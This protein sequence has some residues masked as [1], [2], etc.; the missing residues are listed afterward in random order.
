MAQEC[1]FFNAELEG[2]E[3]DRVYNAEQFA[4]Y[5]A[6]FIANGV[7]GNSMGELVVLEN[8]QANM[9]VDV[10]SG[11]AWINGWWY[12]NTEELNLPIALADGVLNRKDIVVLRWGNAERDMWLQVLQGEPSGEPIAPSIV[13]NADYYDLK[14]CEISIPAGTSR[15]TQSLITDTR[16][17]NNVCGLV[18]GVVDQIDTTELYLQFRSQFEDFKDMS[19]EEFNE[20]FDAIKG[21]ITTDLGIRLQLEIGDLSELETEDKTDLVSAINEAASK[22]G[23]PGV[24]YNTDADAEAD[25]ANIPEDSMVYTN[26]GEDEPINARQIKYDDG[27]QQGSDVETQINNINNDLSDKVERMTNVSGYQTV[28]VL[29]YNPTTKKLGLKVNGADTVIPFNSGISNTFSYSLVNNKGG[30][31]DVDI[32][33]PQGVSSITINYTAKSSYVSTGVYVDGTFHDVT[34]SP[35]TYPVSTKITLHIFDQYTNNS[36]TFKVVFN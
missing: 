4:A 7:F 11:Q 18:T 3:Y 10:S 16:L 30:N 6:S 20:W 1:G 19:K 12:R 28:D 36:A 5:F 13:R 2:S 31:T 17:D 21:Q 25:I 9:S 24:F 34:S 32:F 23:T 14:L 27:T 29:G 26:D 15:I 33:I 8:Q 22:G 35:I